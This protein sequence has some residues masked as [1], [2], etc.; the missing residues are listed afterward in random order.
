MY[1]LEHRVDLLEQA[2]VILINKEKELS[3]WLNESEVESESEDLSE[4]EEATQVESDLEDPIE[5]KRPRN[6]Q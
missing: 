5:Q 1:S 4:N 3:E 2:V 6:L